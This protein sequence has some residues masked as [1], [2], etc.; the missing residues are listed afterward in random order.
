VTSTTIHV[1]DDEI[2]GDLLSYGGRVR[3]AY[4]DIG[5]VRLIFDSP[6]QAARLADAVLAAARDLEAAL[7]VA[8]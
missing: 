3:H 7:V 4:V 6:E 5:N 1:S 8:S 2:T